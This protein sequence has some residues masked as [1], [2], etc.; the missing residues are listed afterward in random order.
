MD[1]QH[2]SYYKCDSKQDSYLNSFQSI[3][4]KIALSLEQSKY[5]CLT[6]AKAFVSEKFLQD[7]LSELESKGFEVNYERWN[8]Y[9]P[10]YLLTIFIK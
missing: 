2:S 1:I 7:V 5:F 4:D 9:T 8:N 10:T 6:S 3:L